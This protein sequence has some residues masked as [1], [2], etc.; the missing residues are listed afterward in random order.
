MPISDWLSL[1]RLHRPPAGG[2]NPVITRY[3]HFPCRGNKR[4]AS[5]FLLEVAFRELNVHVLAVRQGQG[6]EISVGPHMICMLGIPDLFLCRSPP[7]WVSD[8]LLP[9]GVVSSSRD[10]KFVISDRVSVSSSKQGSASIKPAL[11]RGICPCSLGAALELIRPN[12]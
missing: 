2:L 11:A 4:R 8:N 1:V 6:I 9:V 12:K 5:R 10:G 7:R 3:K